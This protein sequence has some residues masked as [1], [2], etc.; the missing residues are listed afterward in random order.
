MKI[1]MKVDKTIARFY[2]HNTAFEV[3]YQATSTVS[4][5]EIAEGDVEQTEIILGID[6]Q[7]KL[8]YSSS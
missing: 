2:M 8:S 4:S 1:L 6:Q 7:D 5:E 3:E